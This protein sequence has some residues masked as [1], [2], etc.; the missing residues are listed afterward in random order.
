MEAHHI[1]KKPLLSEKVTFQTE[2]SNRYAFQVAV[3]ARKDEIKQAIEDLY[4][5]DVI[6]INTVTHR[7]RNRRMRYGMV[8]GKTTKKAIVRIKENQRIELI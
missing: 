8:K 6:K 1:I 5:V 2:D 3:T 4:K 7:T